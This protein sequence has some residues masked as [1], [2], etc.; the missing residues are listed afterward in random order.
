MWCASTALEPSYAGFPPTVPYWNPLPNGSGEDD[1][2]LAE[3]LICGG[4]VQG[5]LGDVLHKQSMRL[6]S[7]ESDDSFFLTVVK[8]DVSICEFFI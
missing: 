8:T 7:L 6:V 1:R 5:H 2:N 3:S 4:C